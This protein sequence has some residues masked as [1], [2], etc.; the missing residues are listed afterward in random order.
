MGQP[1][2]RQAVGRHQAGAVVDVAQS[3]V[4]SALHQPMHARHA[5]VIAPAF[6][7]AA[8]YG[9]DSIGKVYRADLHTKDVSSLAFG[10]GGLAQRAAPQTRFSAALGVESSSSNQAMA[11][12]SNSAL[13]PMQVSAG[14]ANTSSCNGLRIAR[15]WRSSF[16]N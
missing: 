4:T 1:D 13:A 7:N 10:E 5:H 2:E 3:L 12:W 11:L 8:F 16:G 14:D 9:L 6:T 15:I